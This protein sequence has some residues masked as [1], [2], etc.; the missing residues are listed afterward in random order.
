MSLTKIFK[1]LKI[2]TQY[3]KSRNVSIPIEN[4][5]VLNIDT[6]RNINGTK[7]QALLYKKDHR[8]LII[9]LISSDNDFNE[10]NEY[11]KQQK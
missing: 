2:K 3:L 1:K 5:E 10:I 4:N 8:P 7:V 11:L 6:W 9:S